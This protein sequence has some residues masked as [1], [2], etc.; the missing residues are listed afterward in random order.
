MYEF[1]EKEIRTKFKETEYGKKL[2]KMLLI[3]AIVS[4]VLFLGSCVAFFLMG[5]G[6]EL[7]TVKED[8]L[9]NILFGITAIS[10]II[11]CYFDG[12]RDGAIA[13]Y[14]LSLKKGKKQK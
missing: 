3:S 11:S 5:A 12:K 8:M 1:S 9:L 13:Q 4:G 2:N 10:V 14:K 7:L 6:R